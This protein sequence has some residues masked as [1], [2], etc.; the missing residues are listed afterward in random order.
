MRR[1]DCHNAIKQV[2][3]SYQTALQTTSVF[4]EIVSRQPEYLYQYN[5][6]LAG[7]R[8]LAEELSD[9]YFIRMFACFESS[10]RH[11]WRASVRDSKPQTRQL[12]SSI[13]GRLGVSQDTL[14]TVQE[15][16][17]FRNYLIHEEHEVQRRFTIEE[18]SGHL[19]TYLA[20]LPLEW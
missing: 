3:G 18:A 6:S 20:R 13:A 5:L 4:I 16:R 1:L 7:L 15:I 11:F 8:Q 19:N 10:L 17:N 14:D 12:L 9:I 2:T